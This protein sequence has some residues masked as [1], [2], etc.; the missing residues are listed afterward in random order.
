MASSPFPNPFPLSSL[1]GTNGITIQGIA[2]ND[3][4]GIQVSAA[5]DVNRDGL[6]DVVVG[7]HMADPGGR[8]NSG[9]AYVVF[10]VEASNTLAHPL[11]LSTL[12]GTNG[13]AIPGLAAGDFTGFAVSGAGDVDGDGTEDLLVGAYKASPTAGRAGAGKVYLI[14]GALAPT[15]ECAL[16][17]H[18]CQV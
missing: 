10:G 15:D 7:A 5:G 17:S 18:N 3:N 6:P 9:T 13:F 8:A 11:R 16:N 4:T 12:D 14:L 2:A 1:D